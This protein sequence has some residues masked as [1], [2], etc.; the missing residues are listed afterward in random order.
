MHRLA[1]SARFILDIGAHYGWYTGVL[2]RANPHA[3]V[4]GFE[5]DPET[6]AYLQRNVGKLN[7]V[8]VFDVALAS[9]HGRAMLNAGSAKDLNSLVRSVGPGIPVDVT[10][11]DEFAEANRITGIDLIKCDVEGAEVEVLR[12]AAKLMGG[13]H[14]PIWMLEV[15][16]SHLA[17]AGQRPGD[18]HEEISVRCGRTYMFSVDHHGRTTPVQA[19]P[20]GIHANLFFVPEQRLKQFAAALR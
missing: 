8:K 20:P 2:A 7:N 16:E 6:F 9:F 11:L 12:G 1:K 18:L 10:S 5:P 19:I 17:E 14:P 13:E 15:V 3:T 4:F